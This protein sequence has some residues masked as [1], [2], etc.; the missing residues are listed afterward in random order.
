MA[1]VVGGGAAPPAY[2]FP[3]KQEIVEYGT[4]PLLNCKPFPSTSRIS[5]EPDAVAV[6]AWPG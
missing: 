5:P 1:G 2:P 3:A 4:F 6:R